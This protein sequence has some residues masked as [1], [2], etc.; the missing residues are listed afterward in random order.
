LHTRTLLFLIIHELVL[1]LLFKQLKIHSQQ[2]MD[3][4]S[5]LQKKKMV[6]CLP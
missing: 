6:N 5:Q 1:D 2:L 4:V 3:L